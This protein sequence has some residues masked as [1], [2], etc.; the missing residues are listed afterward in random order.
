MLQRVLRNA[1]YDTEIASGG[2][3]ALDIVQ[4]K[5]VDIVLTDI[6]MP[7]MTGRE[8][9]RKLRDLDPALPVIIMTAYSDLRDAV[10]M[11]THEGAAYYIEKPIEDIAALTAEI[12]RAMGGRHAAGDEKGEAV[13]EEWR[14]FEGM[15]G[16]SA[17]M[18]RLTREMRRFLPLLGGP[19]TVLITGES[20]TG[21][22]LVARALH[23]HGPRGEAPFVPVHCAAIPEDLMEAELFG[24][25]KGA[26]TGS[27]QTRT[28]YFQEAESG[29]IF[30]DEIAEMSL[31]TQVK[32]LRV[33]AA[34]QFNRVGSPRTYDANVCVMAATNR[35]L[36]EEVRQKRFRDDLFY[37]L[38]V[39][40]LHVSPLRDRR[41]DIPQ[42]AAHLLQ[43]FTAAF[44]L[45]PKTCSEEA[46][47]ALRRFQWLG[48][49]RQLDH[50]IQQAVV[51]SDSDVVEIEDLPA[52]TAEPASE[53]VFLT[54]VLERGMSLEDVE[55]Q[56]I[57]AALS[58]ADGNQTLAAKL[59]G[60]SRR[61]FQYR[62]DKHHISSR[63]IRDGD[64]TDEDPWDDDESAPS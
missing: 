43:R 38:D 55:Q 44:D 63:E 17:A 56:L 58:R 64:T 30:L 33:L 37:R 6:R 53:P 11:V 41:D 60:V 31:L 51:M 19:A 9:L 47:G 29:T 34:R 27:T 12:D 7:G 4:T 8:L 20:G 49:V 1:G 24:A 23:D 18:R 21:K 61:K 42:L 14:G 15:I 3:S 48:N 40:R 45:P 28:G 52:E 35:D 59:L 54:E 39:F 46:L 36:E 5:P 25:E 13:D 22:E 2:E 16:S 10:E 62:M 26:Y 57:L 32:L 50:Y